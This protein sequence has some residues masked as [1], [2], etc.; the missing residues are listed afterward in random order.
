MNIMVLEKRKI[1]QPKKKVL[2]VSVLDSFMNFFLIPYLEMFHEKG[3][4]VHVA[5]SE[6]G[7]IPFCDKKHQISLSRSPFRLNNFSAVKQLENIIKDNNFDIIHCH[8]PMGGVVTRLA[9]R[10][11]HKNGTKVI[12]T[13]HGFHFF[14][15]APFYYWMLF[16]PVEKFLARFTDTL[17]TINK[18][19]FDLASKKFK[20]CK[21]IKYIPGV[22]VDAEKINPKM[23]A[24]EKLTLR[25]SLG[26]KKDDFVMIFP[27]RL[28]K[29]K[30]QDFLINAMAKIVAKYSK[31]HLLLPGTDELNGKYQDLVKRTHLANNVHILGLRNDIPKLLQIS[32]LAVSSSKREGLPVNIIESMCAGLPAVVSN[33]RGNRD[34]VCKEGGKIFGDEGE[35]L[36]AVETFYRNRDLCK[37]CGEFNRKQSRQYLFGSISEQYEQIYFKKKRIVYIRST[38]I[39]SDSRAQKEIK[40]L[41]KE[42]EVIALGWNRSLDKIEQQPDQLI[43]FNQKAEYGAGLKNIFNLLHF[44]RWITRQLKNIDNIDC[45]YACDF[46]TA[47][48]ARKFAKKHHLKFIYDIYDYYIDCHKLPG[49]MSKL[50]EKM[51]IQT[52]NNSDLTIICSEQ[53]L[54]Q[55]KKTHPR[56]TTIIHNSIDINDFDLTKNI[57]KTPKNQRT[58][59]VYV[60]ILQEDRLL[61]EIAEKIKNED[62]LELHIGGFGKY[63]QYLKNLAKKYKNIFFYGELKYQ[64]VLNLEKSCDV[65]FATYN[66]AIPNHQYS[67]PNKVYEALAL[68]KPI[69]V[70]KNTG[71][72]AMVLDNKFGT[73]IE[74]DGDEFIK[75]VKNAKS[76][77]INPA[78]VKKYGWETMAKTLLQNVGEVLKK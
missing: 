68:G 39:I 60:G 75:A 20:K 54:A 49:I 67:A 53:R 56:K 10:K 15:G 74:Y 2:F 47:Y 5:T 51:D 31:I 30:S 77:K 76:V 38:S 36:R 27:A 8:T 11:F 71:I 61:Q 6:N 48:T 50:I 25:E 43:L 7:K 23:T 1:Q 45:V 73:A 44:Q 32:D 70:C 26:L 12:Y 57:C 35:F 18:D 41:E 28:D 40:A 66:P 37:Q 58:K 55:I 14:K 59:I 46:D 29:N 16:Y 24:T 64:E 3:Y 63:G 22:G 65:L 17:I 4:E 62:D 21:N 9:A 34:L 69:I 78:V 72:D 52:L 33:C 13:A 19:D 42:Y